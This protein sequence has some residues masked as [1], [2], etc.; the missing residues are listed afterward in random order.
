M[1]DKN[2]ITSNSNLNDFTEMKI[3]GKSIASVRLFDSKRI[4]FGLVEAKRLAL[5]I[6]LGV[7]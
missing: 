5:N 6:D 1:K 3:E 2:F 4:F 7:L